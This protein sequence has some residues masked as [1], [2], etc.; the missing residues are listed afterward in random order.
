[1][2]TATWALKVSSM[3]LPRGLKA[4]FPTSYT[5]SHQPFFE[6]RLY[7]LLQSQKDPI[8]LKKGTILEPFECRMFTPSSVSM[9]RMHQYPSNFPSEWSWCTSPSHHCPSMPATPRTSH[10]MALCPS[11]ELSSQT[12]TSNALSSHKHL[13][14]LCEVLVH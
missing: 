10:L 6:V 9:L 3:G 8:S 7:S 12:K 13:P 5:S 14:S 2:Q 1:M 11:G 4:L